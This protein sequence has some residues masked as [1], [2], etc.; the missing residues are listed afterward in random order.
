MPTTVM[1]KPTMQRARA[2]TSTQPS[3]SRVEVLVPTP[4]SVPEPSPKRKDEALSIVIS[5]PNVRRATVTVVGIS[6]YVQHKFSHKALAIM[7]ATQRAGS[8]A[9]KG[10]KREARDFDADYHAAMHISTDG[11]V[12]IPCPSFRN[13][14]IDACRLVGFQMT[15]AKLA[16]FVES[17]GYDSED[18][19]PLI[20]IIGKPE[21]HKGFARNETGVADIRWRPMWREWSAN[22]PLRWDGDQFSPDDILNLLHRA[23]LQVGIGE[24]RPSSPNSFGLGWGLFEIAQ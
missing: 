7:E 23:G 9:K 17:D 2:W 19:T 3:S 14:M 10:R 16:V 4:N 24:G 22:V 15:R 13:A 11:W 20:R 18:G 12:G 21:I 5:P 6:P 8:L 1:A